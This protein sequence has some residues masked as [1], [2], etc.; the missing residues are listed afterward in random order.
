M[1]KYKYL[2]VAACHFLMTRNSPKN[3]LKMFAGNIGFSLYLQ[4]LIMGMKILAS[5]ILRSKLVL[6]VEVTRVPLHIQ[7]LYIWWEITLVAFPANL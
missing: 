3:A 4:D 6:S 1:D 2:K 5:L 7:P